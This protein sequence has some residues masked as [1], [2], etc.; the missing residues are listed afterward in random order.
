M[1]EKTFAYRFARH[2]PVVIALMRGEAPLESV[3]ELRKVALQV[4]KDFPA[5]HA[6][7][8][9]VE[10]GAPP[11]S[12]ALQ[13]ALTETIR[14]LDANLQANVLVFEGAGYEAVAVRAVVAGLA[15]LSGR[16]QTVVAT[17]EAGARQLVQ[18]L[19]LPALE[20]ETMAYVATQQS[21]WQSASFA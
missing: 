1:I 19:G 5:G 11:P 2:G 12:P 13:K 20:Q 4:V 15:F 6:S 9:V 21:A 17:V 7:L 8:T 10:R 3:A 14:E 18:K 16:R